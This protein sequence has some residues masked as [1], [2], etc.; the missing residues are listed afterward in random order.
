MRQALRLAAKAAGR[1]AP[2]PAVGAVIVRKRRV[3]G[4]GYHRGAGHPHAEA[5]ALRAAGG[6]ARGATLYVTLEPCNHTG[7]TPPCCDAIL[8]A[9]IRTVVAAARDPNPHVRGRG[10]V[11][12]RRAGVQVVLGVR[13]DEA[14]ALNAPFF[15]VMATGLP[16]VIAK[17]GQSLDGKIATR[18]GASHWITS[19]AARRAA[20]Q[21][22]SRVD[23][24][25]IGVNTL[26]RDDPLLTVRGAPQRPGR[27]V[28]VIVDSRL[29][30]PPGAACLSRR[31]PAPTI[32][33]AVRPER[34]CAAR[35]ARQG[36]EVVAFPGSRGRVPLRALCRVLARRGLHSILVEGG[37]EVIGDAFAQ[38]LV[39]RVMFFVAPLVI[40]G[41]STT[42]SVGGA[43]VA[44]LGQA[45]RLAGWTVRPVG[46]DVCV[47]ARVTY[48]GA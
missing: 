12:L 10:L 28:K 38:R 27:P 18:T 47:E 14:K 23:A 8:A 29:R 2:N 1:T 30:T 21:W 24:I 22:R 11:R 34:R 20:H 35:L 9:G 32:I 42:P 3:V 7:R 36:A 31:S 39:D 26:L 16:Y 40:G 45:A 15:K 4:T 44:R 46:P 6:L 5:E 19:P 33:A 48:P 43:G 13:E 41:R 25:L 17:V 37:G